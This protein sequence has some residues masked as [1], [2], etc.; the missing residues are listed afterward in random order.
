MGTDEL[1]HV[2]LGTLASKFIGHLLRDVARVCGLCRA[3]N[4]GVF[5]VLQ[6]EGGPN[7]GELLQLDGY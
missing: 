1:S 2:G 7:I 5:A 4:F 3:Q 6:Y